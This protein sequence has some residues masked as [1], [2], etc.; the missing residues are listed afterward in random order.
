MLSWTPAQPR[1]HWQPSL[2]V[3]LSIVFMK[4]HTQEGG[5]GMGSA[6][7]KN[8]GGGNDTIKIL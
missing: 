5:D 4:T 6:S 1:V 2:D 8:W 7:G 3:Y